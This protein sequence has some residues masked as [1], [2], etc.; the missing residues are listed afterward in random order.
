MENDFKNLHSAALVLSTK[1]M[2]QLSQSELDLLAFY[3]TK[4]GKLYMELDLPDCKTV[5]LRL[6]EI[7]GTSHLIAKLGQA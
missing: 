6:R 2:G 7:E 5:A 3:T 1:M 4:G